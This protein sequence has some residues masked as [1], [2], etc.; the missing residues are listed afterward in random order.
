MPA[1]T[2]QMLTRLHQEASCSH[3]T[4]EARTKLKGK[5]LRR[6]RV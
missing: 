1:S 6:S 3:T 2:Q 5:A 4:G